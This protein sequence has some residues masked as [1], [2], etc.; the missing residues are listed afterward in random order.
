M[1]VVINNHPRYQ[2]PLT[3]ILETLRYRDHLDDII[4]CVSDVPDTE[5]QQLVDTYKAMY[6]LQHVLT[7][8]ENIDEYTAYICLGNSLRNGA[9]ADEDQFLMIHDTCEAG[10]LFWQKLQ[11]LQNVLKPPQF[12]KDSTSFKTNEAIVHQIR[13]SDGV[14]LT[15]RFHEFVLVDNK[16]MTYCSYEDQGNK[17]SFYGYLAKDNTI[18]QDDSKAQYFDDGSDL[19]AINARLRDAYLWYPV[20]ANFNIGVATRN[21]VIDHASIAFQGKILSKTESIDIEINPDNP[22]N[23]Q[24]QA[25]DRWRFAFCTLGD[26]KACRM[27][28]MSIW[29]ND[30]DV[31]GDGKRRNV[32]FIHQLDLKKFSVLVGKAW[33]P[34]H[35]LRS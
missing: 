11:E 16:L 10:R 3:L 21:F 12:D 19:D 32:A 28:T 34:S 6:G 17:H 14:M 1:K 30:T 20:S 24:T 22:L 15:M 35:P 23:L 8:S 18:T 5:S 7:T 9:F 31:Y 25:G 2:Q 13:S 4:V 27:P 29:A 33:L 26:T